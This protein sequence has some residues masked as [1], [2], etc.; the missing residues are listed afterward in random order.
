[1]RSRLIVAAIGVPLLYLVLLSSAADNIALVVTLA[2][3]CGIACLELC[4]MLRPV[5]PYVPAALAPVVLSPLLAWQLGEVGIFLAMMSTVPLVLAFQGLSVER[6]QPLVAILATMAPVLYIAPP[7][8]LAVILR[9]SEAGFGLLT[10]LIASVFLNDSGAYC[11]GRLIGRHKLSPKISPNKSI[12]GFVGGVAI[13]TFVMWYGH[14]LVQASGH[15]VLRGGEALALGLAV[16]V[17]TPVG[18]LFESLLK[19]SA[20]V[21]DSGN[22]LGE[23]GGMLDRVDALLLALPTMYVGCF[24]VGAL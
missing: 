18:D 22:L 7:A 6:E 21:K 20:G 9:Q 17:A 2:V 10:L 12:E 19:R 3:A 5:G 23:H 24:L 15:D 1:M 11:V 16:A 13:G 4:V 14:F 8:G